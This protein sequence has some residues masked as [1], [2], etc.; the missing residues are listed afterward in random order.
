MKSNFTV[1]TGAGKALVQESKRTLGK[2]LSSLLYCFQEITKCF[3]F[4]TLLFM[5]HGPSSPPLNS[6]V[7]KW[8]PSRGLRLPGPPKGSFASGSSTE[9]FQRGWRD[10]ARQKLWDPGHPT[11]RP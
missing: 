11:Q 7:P 10:E 6:K 5:P 9:R 8:D 4:L 3:H 1:I 2:K